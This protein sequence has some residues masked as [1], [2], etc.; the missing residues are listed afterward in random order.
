MTNPESITVVDANE[1][2]EQTKT[3]KRQYEELAELIESFREE[4]HR[5]VDPM[6]DLMK[7][8]K[9]TEA[10][11]KPLRE[12]FLASGQKVTGTLKEVTDETIEI[13]K[14]LMPMLGDLE[15]SSV[16]SLRRLF[17]KIQGSVR[18]VQ[19]QNAYKHH[20]SDSV[21]Q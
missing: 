10:S 8:I 16:D 17:P 7:R 11:L 5:E 20:Q 21:Q 19:M 6:N 9:Q 15:K 14:S 12:S 3:L 18:A 1:L 13:V 4:S 2:L